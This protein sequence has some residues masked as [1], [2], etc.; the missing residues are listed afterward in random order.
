MQKAK[1]ISL[2]FRIDG[3]QTG[4]FKTVEGMAKISSAGIVLE[5][6]AKIFGIMRTGIK[7]VCIPLGEIV[8]IKLQE[9]FFKTRLEIWLNNFKTLSEVPN[10]EGRIVMQ[11][12]KQDRRRAAEALGLLEK[13]LAEQES[14][15][16]RTPVSSLFDETEETREP[17]SDK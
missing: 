2:P 10:K 13:S 6:E 5:F 17:D 11:I 9:R 7:K 4:G 12:A 14:V 16:P 1:F 3:A 15:P 8:D